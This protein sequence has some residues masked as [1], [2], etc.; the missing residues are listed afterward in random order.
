M[1][2]QIYD[3]IRTLTDI[4]ADFSDRVIPKGTLGTVIEC[5]EKP[6]GYAVD[7][8]IPDSSLVGD[9]SYENVVLSPDQFVVVNHSLQKLSISESL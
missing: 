3:Q 7:L 2:A 5:Y 4:P 9:F 1:K 6:E 8:A